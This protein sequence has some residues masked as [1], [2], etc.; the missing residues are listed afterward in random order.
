MSLQVGS[1][2]PSIQVAKD[3]IKTA[4]AEAQQ[5]WKATHSD[6]TRYNIICKETTC[7][8]RIRVSQRGVECVLHTIFLILVALLCTSQQQTPTRYNFLF[9]IIEL[10]L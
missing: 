10:Q 9:P 2:F 5:S 1:T 6:K 3:T 8:F 7:N 4:L